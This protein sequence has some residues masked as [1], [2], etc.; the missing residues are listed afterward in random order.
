MLFCVLQIREH[1]A[2]MVRLVYAILM[3]WDET[4]DNHRNY[5]LSALRAA[6]VFIRKLIYIY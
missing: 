4:T 3:K 2:Y 6:L 1:D 5:E